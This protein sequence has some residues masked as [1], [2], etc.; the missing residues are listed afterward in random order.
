MS[1]SLVIRRDSL[2]GIISPL[3]GT[4][5]EAKT[6]YNI[7]KEQFDKMKPSAAIYRRD[8]LNKQIKGYN[9]NGNTFQA[10]KLK[11]ILHREKSRNNWR[12]INRALE[13]R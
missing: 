8:F 6:A 13:Q 5:T 10:K 4:G 3:E 12:L 1:T 9:S 7:C 2:C 11:E